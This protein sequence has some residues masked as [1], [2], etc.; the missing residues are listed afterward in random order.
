[1]FL[2]KA[3]SRIVA[4]A[5]CPSFYELFDEVCAR[6]GRKAEIL[7]GIPKPK[8]GILHTGAD[9][10]AWVHRELSEDIE[11]NI[12]LKEQKPEYC[13]G[14]GSI[15]ID[16]LESNIRAWEGMGGTGILHKSTEETRERLKGMGV[17]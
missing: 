6:Y 4:A 10:T 15:L 1:M 12:V 16:D 17:L 13:K 14:K 5:G 7:T 8:R 9:K 3:V 11:V 2:L